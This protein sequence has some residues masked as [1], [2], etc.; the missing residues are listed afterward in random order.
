M[1]Y[2]YY[3]IHYYTDPCEIGP[4]VIYRIRFECKFNHRGKTGG[5]GGYEK[6]TISKWNDHEKYFERMRGHEKFTTSS[7]ISS[8]PP[9]PGH[10]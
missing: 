7:E 9:G 1:T 6:N 5:G 10:F 4:P 3:N 2:F 8:S